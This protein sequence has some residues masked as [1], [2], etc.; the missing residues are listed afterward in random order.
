[1]SLR[2]YL[3]AFP[4]CGERVYVD[5]AATVIG[6]VELGDDVSVWPGCVIRG[7]VNFIRIGARSN[8]QDGAVVHVT[9][10]GPFTRPG[11]LPTLIGSDVTVGHGAIV[12][13]CTI[14]DLCLIGM[15]AK[16]LDGA[17][18]RRYGFVGAGAVVA[19]GKTVGEAELW[20]GNPARCVRRLSEREIEQLHYSARHYVRLKDRY[21]GMPG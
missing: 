12:H 3:D 7:D 2:P 17:R 19:P 18:V 8:V 16:V 4:T 5:P 20:L 9:H 6:A 1:M 11:G 21:L 14:E 15:G 13:A 10:E